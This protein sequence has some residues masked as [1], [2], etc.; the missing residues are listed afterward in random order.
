MSRQTNNDRI[1]SL[2]YKTAGFTN[3]FQEKVLDEAAHKSLRW[4]RYTNDISVF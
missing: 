1:L 3:D 2:L 4:F